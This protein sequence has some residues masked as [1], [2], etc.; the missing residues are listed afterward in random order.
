[1]YETF[2]KNRV[3]IGAIPSWD[4]MDGFRQFSQRG[5][6]RSLQESE[7]GK[8]F[9]FSFRFFLFFF[10]FFFLIFF[11]LFVF[12]VQVSLPWAKKVDI[13]RNTISMTNDHEIILAGSDWSY[14]HRISSSSSGRFSPAGTRAG[15]HARTRT[16]TD[17]HTDAQSLLING[18]FEKP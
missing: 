15:T 17:A 1:M 16:H 13:V 9:L 10:S 14:F 8:K 11:L 5:T 2:W 4:W 3:R 18:L 6:R 12:F 7:I